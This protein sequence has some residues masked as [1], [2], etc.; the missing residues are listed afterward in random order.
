MTRN[1]VTNAATT[2]RMP[3][4]RNRMSPRFTLPGCIALKPT[5]A[6]V[7][8]RQT[9]VPAKRRLRQ[10]PEVL[11]HRRAERPRLRLVGEGALEHASTGWVG[12]HHPPP[13]P[14]RLG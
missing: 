5:S 1:T 6:P 13:L 8:I 11:L 4:T 10:P 9:I 3:E 12:D 7:R 14:M 2:T